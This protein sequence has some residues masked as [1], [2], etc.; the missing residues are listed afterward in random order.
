MI[1]YNAPSLRSLPVCDGLDE[2]GQDLGEGVDF[3]AVL[4]RGLALLV[5]DRWVGADADEEL[6]D[7]RRLCPGALV[8]DRVSLLILKKAFFL[9]KQI[10]I[11]ITPVLLVDIG[12]ARNEGLDELDADLGCEVKRRHAVE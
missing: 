4:D 9:N 10:D 8:Q 12:A 6:G 3:F 11:I 2:N 5:L 1:K 7:G